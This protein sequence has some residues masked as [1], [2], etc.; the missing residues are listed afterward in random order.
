MEPHVRVYLDDQLEPIIDQELPSDAS[1]DTSTLEDG[2]HRLTI[3]AVGENGRE[4]VEIIPFQVRNGP[5]ITVSGLTAHSTRRGKVQFKI[6]AFSADDPFDPR[7][8]ESHSSI[9]IWVWVLCLFVLSW[10]VWYAARM[11]DVPAEFAHTPTFS[12]QPSGPHSPSH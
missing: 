9:P 10:T 1:L 2:H 7:R 12:S 6:N 5:G 8:A 3:R 4:G 11:W